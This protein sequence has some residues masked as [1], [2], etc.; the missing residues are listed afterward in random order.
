MS[1]SNFYQCRRTRAKLWV[2]EELVLQ[3]VRQVRAHHPQVGV[4]K[5]WKMIAPELRQAGVAMGRDRMFALLSRH[6]MLIARRGSGV[7]TTQSRH[8]LRVYVN[9]AKSL[10]LTGPNQLWVSD[11]T[12]VRTAEGFVYLCLTMDAFSRA[13]VGF[14]CSDS[15]EMQGA[16]SALEQAIAQ[17]P[18]GVSTTHHSDRGVQYCCHAYIDRL[19]RSGIQ[20]SMTQE[21]HCAENAKAERLNGIL[22]QEYGL[23]E[24]LPSKR[25]AME[26]SVQAVGLYND[27]RLH[28]ALGYRPPMSVHRACVDRKSPGVHGQA[29]QDIESRSGI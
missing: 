24:T 27:S 11:L 10:D 12:Y 6:E 25:V 5:L 7:R 1:R 4:R 14:D 8:G 17:R 13:I 18:G 2:D 15:L 23:G 16:L 20:I 26:M 22:K 9:I 28:T 29:L 3:L 21:D 19:K